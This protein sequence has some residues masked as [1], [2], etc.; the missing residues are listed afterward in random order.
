MECYEKLCIRVNNKT[1]LYFITTHLKDWILFNITKDLQLQENK[2]WQ[3]YPT[4]QY[5]NYLDFNLRSVNT[6]KYIIELKDIVGSG[7]CKLL[8]LMIAMNWDENVSK[9]FDNDVKDFYSK[10]GNNIKTH[11]HRNQSLNLLRNP[12]NLF[13]VSY[14]KFGKWLRERKRICD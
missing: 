6:S 13:S 10:L 7:N 14:H 5:S 1:S 4:K 12:T 9:W 11:N 8:C 2:Q 3:Q